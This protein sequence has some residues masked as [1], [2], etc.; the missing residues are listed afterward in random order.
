MPPTITLA[1]TEPPK[2]IGLPGLRVGT[3]TVEELAALM[4]CEFTH[5]NIDNE[6][7][8]MNIDS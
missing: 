7:K 8:N 2:V 1:V 3:E 6:I 5:R 4:A